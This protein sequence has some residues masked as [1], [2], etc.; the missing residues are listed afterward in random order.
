MVECPIDKKKLKN[1]TCEY[2]EG[3]LV[4]SDD[5]LSCEEIKPEVKELPKEKTNFI[6]Y[7]ID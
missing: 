6:E 3:D 1:G 4:P 2:C 7:T 5:Q